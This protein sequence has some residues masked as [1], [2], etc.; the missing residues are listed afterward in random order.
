MLEMSS[1]KFSDLCVGFSS[2]GFSEKGYFYKPNFNLFM[3]KN[4]KRDK[5]MCVGL[6]KLPSN[7][8]LGRRNA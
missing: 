2:F 7:N 6:W 3:D 4:F 5:K 8:S 1:R